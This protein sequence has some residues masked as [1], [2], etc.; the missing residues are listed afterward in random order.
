MLTHEIVLYG[1]DILLL[2]L[3][4][5]GLILIFKSKIRKKRLCSVLLAILLFILFIL[6]SLL[7]IE[8]PFLTFPTVEEAFHYKYDCDILL[9]VEGNKS[10]QVICD[11]GHSSGYH[12]VVLPKTDKGWKPNIPLD[13]KIVE[14]KFTPSGAA[15]MLQHFKQTDDFYLTILSSSGMD[16][17]SDNRNTE[18]QSLTGPSF[19]GKEIPPGHYYASLDG[20]DENYVLTIDGE[21]YTFPKAK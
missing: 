2:I 10:T 14:E 6:S 12:S 19:L 9:T 17:L 15:V 20:V 4:I 1:I 7:P 3:L 8:E 11:L 16:E 21:D 18:F 13:T 5:V